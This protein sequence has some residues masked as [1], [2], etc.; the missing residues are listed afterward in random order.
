M[1]G[2]SIALYGARSD[3]MREADPVPADVSLYGMTKRLGEMLGERFR[4]SDGLEFVA[5]RYSGVFGPGAATSPGMAQ[6]RQRI[7]QCARGEDVVVEGA[8]GDERIHLTY[9]TDAAEATCRAL[10]AP[11]PAHSIYNVAGPAENYVSLH[12]LHALVGE[13]VPGTGRALWSG[14]A[15]SAGLVDTTRIAADLGW[16]PA[17]SLKE[18]LRQV[19]APEPRGAARAVA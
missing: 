18:G 13:I 6:V 3:A 15:R 5:L 12:E 14:R 9:V 1:F 11:V 10:L 17:I 16:R 8:S 19:L 4:S 7:L 2:S